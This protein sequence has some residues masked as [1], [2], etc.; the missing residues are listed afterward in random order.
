MERDSGSA[1]T[2]A[3]D[4]GGDLV[5]EPK[6]EMTFTELCQRILLEAQRGGERAELAN[7]D[8][9]SVIEA[10]MPSVLQEVTTRY[11]ANPSTQS[12]LRQSHTVAITSGVG[13]LPDTVLTEC[14]TGSMVLEP[15]DDEAFPEDVAFIP[16]YV[17]FAGAKRYEPRLG[18]YCVL[19]NRVIHYVSPTGDY[20]DFTGNLTYIGATVLSV[21]ADPDI[22]T[23]WDA[24]AESNVINLAAEW[25]RGAKIAA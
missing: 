24:E 10:I 19:G 18:Y 5:P 2:S 3:G 22:P 7:L 23:G 1:G 13:T 9:Q 25:L 11:A 15:D 12:L 16:Q 6:I 17:N 8:T 21:P 4:G 20:G 14:L